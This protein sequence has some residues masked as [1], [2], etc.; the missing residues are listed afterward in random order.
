MTAAWG[1]QGWLGTVGLLGAAQALGLG[2]DLDVD[3]DGC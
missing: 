3:K 1:Q 2:W